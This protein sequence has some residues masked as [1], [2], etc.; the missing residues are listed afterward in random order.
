MRVG[1]L[2]FVLGAWAYCASSDRKHEFEPSPYNRLQVPAKK[3]E[4]RAV[5]ETMVRDQ[6]AVLDL[7]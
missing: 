5:A 6:R 7:L 2:A 3:D 1:A 4:I